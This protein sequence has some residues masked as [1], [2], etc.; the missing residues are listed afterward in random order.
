MNLLE[1]CFKIIQNIPNS[2]FYRQ[3]SARIF[4]EKSIDP[5]KDLLSDIYLYD[6]KGEAYYQ[7]W[8]ARNLRFAS[9]TQRVLGFLDAALNILFLPITL[10]LAAVKD[11]FLLLVKLPGFITINSVKV[12]YNISDLLARFM[13]PAKQ[14]EPEVEILPQTIDKPRDIFIRTS[15]IENILNT[16]SFADVFNYR[17]SHAKQLS[18]YAK[19]LKEDAKTGIFNNLVDDQSLNRQYG[20]DSQYL[21]K[22][23]GLAANN[24]RNYKMNALVLKLESFFQTATAYLEIAPNSLFFTAYLALALVKDIFFAPVKAAFFAARKVT[25][26]YHFFKYIINS[27][28]PKDD[29]STENSQAQSNDLNNS[30][31]LGSFRTESPPIM[32]PIYNTPRKENPA[33]F[34]SGNP[35]AEY[36]GKNPNSESNQ[37]NQDPVKDELLPRDNPFLVLPSNAAPKF[38][39]DQ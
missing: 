4:W 39:N 5:E 7:E 2:Y 25:D 29:P 27:I 33:G 23:Y 21:N 28:N 14:S 20:F 22:Q 13:N 35:F 38:K 6:K 3:E 26:F 16:M 10:P 8:N 37:N 19:E 34:A 17:I 18:K 30:P 9:R 24:I 11:L 31:R 15:F 36:L 32:L 12:F 1:N